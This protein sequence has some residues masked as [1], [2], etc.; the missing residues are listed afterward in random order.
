MHGPSFAGDCA[1]ALSALADGYAERLF[2]ASGSRWVRFNERPEE[3]ADDHSNPGGEH[4]APDHACEAPDVSPPPSTPGMSDQLSAELLPLQTGR[5]TDR[6]PT[7]GTCGP[8]P[9][10][11]SA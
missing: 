11:A 6:V 5:K 3:R 2:E 1:A 10:T 4:P 9:G 7:G 8:W